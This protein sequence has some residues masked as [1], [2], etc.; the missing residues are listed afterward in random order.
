MENIPK[1]G[2]GGQEMSQNRALVEARMIS[3]WLLLLVDFEGE[4]RLADPFY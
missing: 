1:Q 2:V 4:L 3:F